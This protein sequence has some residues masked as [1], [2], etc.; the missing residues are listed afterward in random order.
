MA[1]DV[2][3]A[4]E[5]LDVIHGVDTLTAPTT[6]MT[7]RLIRINGSAS[8]A[9]TEVTA[10]AGGGT[11]A[12]YTAGGEDATFTAAAAGAATLDADV[13]WANM[14]ATTVAG[15]EVWDSAVTPKRWEW[16]TFTPRVLGSGDGFTLTPA[17]FTSALS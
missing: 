16:G 14:P 15:I 4:N 10:G 3:R 8:A 13:V 5:L 12:G 6:P 2:N 17:L 1:L 9:G 11:G 7:I